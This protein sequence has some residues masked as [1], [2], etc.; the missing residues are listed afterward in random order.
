MGNVALPLL[1]GVDARDCPSAEPFAARNLEPQAEMVEARDYA[2][3]LSVG[4]PKEQATQLLRE[5]HE[6]TLRREAGLLGGDSASH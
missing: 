6:R 1:P 4:G 2:G 5:F 3:T